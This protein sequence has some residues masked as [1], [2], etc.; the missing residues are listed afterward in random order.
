L[1]LRAGEDKSAPPQM[2]ARFD[3][4]RNGVDAFLY[5]FDLLG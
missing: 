1:H 5:A 3:V 4:R 2:C